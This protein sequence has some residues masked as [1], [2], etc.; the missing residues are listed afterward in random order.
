[1]NELGAHD[2]RQVDARLP[3]TTVDPRRF[4]IL[5]AIEL[6]VFAALVTFL[7]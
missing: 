3:F 6:A 5:I 2:S 7:N 1:M 4:I